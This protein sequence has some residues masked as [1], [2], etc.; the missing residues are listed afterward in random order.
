VH[1]WGSAIGITIYFVML[2]RGGLLQ[3]IELNLKETPFMEIV[4]ATI[5]YLK[6][7]SVGGSLM[8]IGHL[9]FMVSFVWMV[10]DRRNR[11]SE[12]TLFANR[13]PGETKSAS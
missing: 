11:G 6:W 8:T 12:P 13:K 4:E 10:I 1:F 5:P 2:S 9:A 3:G 7:R